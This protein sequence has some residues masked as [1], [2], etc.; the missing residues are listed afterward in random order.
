MYYSEN[1]SIKDT[2]HKLTHSSPYPWAGIPTSQKAILKLRGQW[3]AQSQK[4]VWLSQDAQLGSLALELLHAKQLKCEQTYGCQQ[5][6][7]GAGIVREL[8]MDMYTL[9]YLTWIT[10]SAY[11]IAQG[12]LLSVTW[13]PG[14]VG[15][16]GEKECMYVYGW[17]PFCPPE[18]IT[19]LLTGYTSLQ[20]KKLKKKNKATQGWWHYC[21]DLNCKNQLIHSKVNTT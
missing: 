1:N 12:T 17:V 13:Q 8:G 5:G 6:G 11:C 21:K 9:L 15:S 14:W 3:H 7:W 20:N 18:T 19:M 4:P 16:L 10:T 2:L